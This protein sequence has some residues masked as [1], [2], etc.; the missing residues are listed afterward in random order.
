MISN[1]TRGAAAESM[2]PA[3][4]VET[5]T[6]VRRHPWWAAR[7]RL[8]LRLLKANGINAPASILDA[9]CGWGVTLD[10][11]EEHGFEVTGIDISEDILAKLDK[12]ARRL[13]IA[14]LTQPLPD[15]RTFRA[16]LALDVIEHVDDDRLVISNLAGAVD[17]GGLLIV[18]VPALPELFSEF[19]HV[20]GHRRR[21]LPERLAEAF[22]GTGFDVQRIFWWG[23]WMIPILKRMRQPV[24][25]TTDST[26]TYAD[27]LRLPAWPLP[28]VMELA[29]RIE[30]PFA[31][32]GKI[33]QGTSLFAL[34]R[35]TS[36]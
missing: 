25:S 17:P 34:A 10:H 36:K 24:S 35:R 12:P 14:D 20:Q 9:G 26:K 33:P 16:A 32:A 31:V 18:S 30:E 23:G 21:Y 27:Y 13:A 5:L 22:V 28:M 8:A 29:Y 4:L 2:E 19:D 11:L 1:W 6:A 3:L 15:G 7:A